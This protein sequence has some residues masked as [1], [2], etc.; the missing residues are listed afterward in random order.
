MT[1]P[2]DQ[3]DKA[4]FS[5]SAQL[6]ES[7]FREA[8]TQDERKIPHPSKLRKG[9]KPGEALKRKP[10]D[11]LQQ[12]HRAAK[13]AVLAKRRIDSAKK[14][15]GIK[16]RSSVS[17]KRD[18]MTGRA[19]D[20]GLPRAGSIKKPGT[21]KPRI[22]QAVLLLIL[23]A[24][25]GVFAASY[26]GYVDLGRPVGWLVGEDT[27]TSAPQA[28]RVKQRTETTQP[29]PA[30]PVPRKPE[31]EVASVKSLPGPLPEAK[32][33]PPE[34][35]IQPTLPKSEV[36][37]APAVTPEPVQKAAR[38]P[39]QDEPTKYPFS[40]FL[41]SFQS[42]DRTK[43][44]VSIYE[45]D[46]GVSAYWVRVDLGDKGIWHRVFTGYFSSAGEAE[47]FIEARDL[48]EGEIRQTKYAML[49]GEFGTPEEAADTVLRLL[50]IG[51]S[52]Y[53]VPGLEDGFKLY[54]GVFNT[55]EDAQKQH[56]ELASKG[57]RNRVVE[58]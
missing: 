12:A 25:G 56:A 7:L 58:R 29:V 37:E 6:F 22:F 2:K 13:D 4:P 47:L 10:Q 30:K 55:P 18:G 14:G 32:E 33:T 1:E 17:L 34:P 15:N 57:I 24:G 49:I 35:V 3:S 45:K 41:G 46:H 23:L 26:L 54:S 27:P 11:R 53:F 39:I 21:G 40:I 8:V 43:K 51:H 52:S 16:P 28:A 50:Q 42:L 44:A 9:A 48:N 20:L 19:S 38:L 31:T 5:D 36:K